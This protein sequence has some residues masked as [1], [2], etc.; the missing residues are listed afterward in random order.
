MSKVPAERPTR[1]TPSTSISVYCE[2]KPCNCMPSPP[3][4]SGIVTNP[5]CSF[6]ISL[7]LMELLLLM[8]FFE[9]I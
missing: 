3:P 9:M 7:S 5:V 6:R 1:G 2:S 8:S 4:K